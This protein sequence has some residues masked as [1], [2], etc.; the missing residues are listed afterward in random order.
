MTIFP[1]GSEFCTDCF[2]FLWELGFL[3]DCGGFHGREISKKN[4]G[5]SVWGV[6]VI[7]A[8]HRHIREERA[9]MWL[10]NVKRRNLSPFR[11]KSV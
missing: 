2:G 7:D 4:K 3:L 1:C 6:F 5:N 11:L 8:R 9:C 10:A